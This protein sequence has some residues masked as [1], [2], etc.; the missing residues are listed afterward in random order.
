LGRITGL[1]EAGDIRPVLDRVFP[2]EELNAA[3]AYIDTGR[4]KG[5]VVV[6]LKPSVVAH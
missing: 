5:K 4:A 6:S 1:I 3:L 2:F